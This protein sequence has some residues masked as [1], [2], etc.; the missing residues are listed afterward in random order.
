MGEPCRSR[1]PEFCKTGTGSVYVVSEPAVMPADRVVAAV[2]TPS[3]GLADLETLLKRLLPN[4]PTLSPPPRPVPTEIET[5]LE[6][7]LSPAPASLPQPVTT[8]M[9]TVLRRLLLPGTQTPAQRSSP[10]PA[11]RDWT[12]VVC[13]SYGKPGP[14]SEQVVPAVGGNIP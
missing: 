1:Q 2:A 9:E 7:L 8:D 11:R 10:V 14:R 6:H 12:K 13:F 5:M 4:V 3:V